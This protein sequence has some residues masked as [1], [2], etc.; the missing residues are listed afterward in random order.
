MQNTY[1]T[2]KFA[3]KFDRHL[4][5]AIL[6]HIIKENIQKQ[7]EI[8]NNPINI[9]YHQSNKYHHRLSIIFAINMFPGG[10]S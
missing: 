2:Y 4:F 8:I 3:I 1:G 6:R 5:R 9:I 10:F 7:I